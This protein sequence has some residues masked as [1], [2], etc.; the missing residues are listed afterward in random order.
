MWE[1]SVSAEGWG[2]YAESLMAESVEGALNGFYAPEERLYQLWYKL[3]RDLRVR[4]DT[5]MHTGKL[6]YD[7]A[8]T[9]FSETRD[10]LPGKCTDAAVLALPAKRASCEA[11]DRAIYRYSKW[12]TQAVTYRVGKDL[13]YAMREEAARQQGRA[14]SAKAFHLAFMAQGQIPPSYFK[15]A[16]LQTLAAQAH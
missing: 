6:G 10:F 14:F 3:Y 1:D 8:V 7:E 13:I 12:P 9:L 5:G 15:D 4:I 11:A 16:L 2:L